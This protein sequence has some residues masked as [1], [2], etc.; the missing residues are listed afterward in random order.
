[1]ADM[2][3]SLRDRRLGGC[4]L[5][6]I[7]KFTNIGFP[8]D[9]WLKAVGR[10]AKLTGNA[11]GQSESADGTSKPEILRRRSKLFAKPSASRIACLLFRKDR[12]LH[13]FSDAK[14]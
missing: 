5:A 6:H 12:V 13:S 9:Q 10:G 7:F 2:D 8:K 14:L 11:Q 3:F 4:A 1:M